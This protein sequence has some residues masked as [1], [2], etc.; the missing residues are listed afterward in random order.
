MITESL[1]KAKIP[2]RK[3][4]IVKIVDIHNDRR[5]VSHVEKIAGVFG[6]V[7]TGTPH[8]KKLFTKDGKHN[9]IAPRFNLKISGTMIRRKMRKGEDIKHLVLWRLT[10]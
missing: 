10:R 6:N 2:A 5:W 4:T 7:Y 3:F 8:V 9:V 1:R